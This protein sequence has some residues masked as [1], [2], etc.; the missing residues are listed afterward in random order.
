MFLNLHVD[1]LVASPNIKF[2]A[3]WDD[4]DFAWNDAQGAQMLSDPSQAEKVKITTSYMR[5]FRKALAAN[6]LSTFPSTSSAPQLWADYMA[7][8]FVPLGAASIKLE[9]DGS[10]WLH[11]TDGRTQR[12]KHQMLGVKQ[13]AM[14]NTAINA[15]PDALHIIASGVTFSQGD[16]WH[17]YPDDRKWLTQAAGDHSW[18]MLSGDVHS[19]GLLEHK[20]SA[21]GR[22]VEATASGA[23]INAYLNEVMK[24]PEL[25]NF[26]L[27]EIEKSHI[28]IRLLAFNKVITEAHYDR[29]NSGDLVV[30]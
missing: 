19:N 1:A 26:G 10:S 30:K 27:L 25:R 22:L 28:L 17:K 21:K 9:Q 23:A 4:H 12:K 14:L 13:H 5:E 3:I 2:H 24:G 15:A 6:D 18:L 16:G 11:L 20:L 7:P 8:D 29:S